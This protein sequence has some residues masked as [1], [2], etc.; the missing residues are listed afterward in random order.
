MKP[1]RV[2]PLLAIALAGAAG[3]AWVWSSRVSGPAATLVSS[4]P[5]PATAQEASRSPAL[6]R[7]TSSPRAEVAH[8]D[9]ASTPRTE[10]FPLD[11]AAWIEGRV[12]APGSA[13]A[14]ETLAVWAFEPS[15]TAAME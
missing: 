11:G 5:P 2:L 10:S 4:E 1:R 12:R 13:P 7:E 8:L 9:A 14:D 15:A 3:L 6:E